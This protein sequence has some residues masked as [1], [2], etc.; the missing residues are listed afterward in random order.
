MTAAHDPRMPLLAME[1]DP[2][3]YW[4]GALLMGS[5]VR[6]SGVS[7]DW[8]SVKPAFA[9]WIA[10]ATHIVA[11]GLL[12][13]AA[14]GAQ[15]QGYPER[16]IR[17]VVPYTP[18]G[19]TD[20]LARTLARRLSE[21]WAQQVLVENRPG[22]GGNIGTEAVAKAPANGY[23]LGIV[24]SSHAIAP[25]LY[26]KLPF[27]NLRDFTFITQVAAG[28]N[29][30]VCHP[31]LPVRSVQSLIALARRRPGE[32]AFASAGVGSTTH[33]AG[34]YFK[35]VA[36]I[37]TL[38]VP[39]KGSSQAQVDLVGGQVAY[40]VD[41]L[42]SALPRIQ[43]ARIRALATTG[44]ARFSLLPAVPTVLESGLRYESVSWWGVV[45]PAGIPPAIVSRLHEAIVRI[46]ALPDVKQVVAAQGAEPVTSTP[47][48]FADHVREETAL[49]ATIVQKANIRVE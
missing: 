24:A 17:I 37:D 15:A 29:V 23:A 31:S 49:Y 5:R 26:R 11:F 40:M 30:V 42:I 48:Q 38:H 12:A 22:G 36:G 1:M 21:A 3:L 7:G 18:G 41:S 9:R 14:M 13:L 43:D 47:Q 34:E 25:A 8:R 4:P 27:H 45:G 44:R 16:P 20:I 32:L 33:L 35:S 6:G 39:Y 2:A 28:P 19:G 46:M 10:H